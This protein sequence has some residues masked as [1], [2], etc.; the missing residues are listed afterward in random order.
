MPDFDQKPHKVVSYVNI[1]YKANVISVKLSIGCKL[2][3]HTPIYGLLELTPFYAILLQRL[4]YIIIY[5]EDNCF[6]RISLV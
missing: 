4:Y 6:V 3:T 2:N 1:D 5:N